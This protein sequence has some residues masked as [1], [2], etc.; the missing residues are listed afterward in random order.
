MNQIGSVRFGSVRFGSIPIVPIWDCRVKD[1]IL[2][3]SSSQS[4]AEFS[5]FRA[6]QKLGEAGQ[7]MECSAGFAPADR[8]SGN[9]RPP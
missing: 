8:K 2:C 4:S 7:F 1:S 6:V 9:L 3:I 5:Q